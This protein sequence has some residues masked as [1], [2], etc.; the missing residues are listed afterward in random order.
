M[1]NFYIYHLITHAWAGALIDITEKPSS[2]IIFFSLH[3]INLGYWL[4]H[5]SIKLAGPMIGKFLEK[6][7]CEDFH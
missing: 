7:L 3:F 6:D 4:Y 5:F 2:L 1:P